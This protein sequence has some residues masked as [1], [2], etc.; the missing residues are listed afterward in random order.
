LT[1][2]PNDE[3][4]ESKGKLGLFCLSVVGTRGQDGTIPAREI[5]THVKTLQ[6]LN[7]GVMLFRARELYKMSEYVNRYTKSRIHFAIGLT[8][9]LRVLE[10]RYKDLPGTVLEGIARLFM[11]NVRVAVYP[12]AS[13]QVRRHLEAAELTGWRWKET[14]GMIAP[15]DLHPPE[16]LDHLY[17]YLLGNEFII[18]IKSATRSVSS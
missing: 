14:N 8:V 17:Q 16:P 13:E 4:T 7:Y 15:D 1:Q 18:P 11:Q 2:L 5:S 10:D 9:L 12:G 6:E 3:L